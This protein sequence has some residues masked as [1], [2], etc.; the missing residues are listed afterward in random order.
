MKSF[1]VFTALLL[2]V[3][4]ATAALYGTQSLAITTVLP[5]PPRID[6]ITQL[7][8]GGLLAGMHP[9]GLIL[10]PLGER[11][12]A[13]EGARDCDIGRF[14]AS[15]KSRRKTKAAIKSEW[16][17]VLRYAKSA[18]SSRIY[19]TLDTLLQFC[20]DAGFLA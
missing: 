17:E 4:G 9:F 8:G 2:A 5:P 14:L 13:T 3:N 7:R 11:F 12:L 6:T 20:L 19:R 18:E 10:T 1:G 16:L 15:L